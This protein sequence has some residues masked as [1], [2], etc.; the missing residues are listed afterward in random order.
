MNLIVNAEIFRLQNDSRRRPKTNQKLRS[1]QFSVSCQTV[2][3]IPRKNSIQH[4]I[5][6]TI[7]ASS[8]SQGQAKANVM[9]AICYLPQMLR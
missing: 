6:K 2:I 5:R 9:C 1:D 8:K 4:E 7:G 3:L